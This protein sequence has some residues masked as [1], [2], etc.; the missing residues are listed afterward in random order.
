MRA[1]RYSSI[2]TDTYKNIRPNETL[3]L[4]A[5]TQSCL[6]S[7]KTRWPMSITQFA[8]RALTLR[9]TPAADP[10]LERVRQGE[11]AAVGE[12]YDLHHE[13]VRAFAVRLVGDESV[14]EDLVHEVF[15]Q[16][17]RCID[18]F[19]GDSSLRTFLT[20]VAVNHAR[21]YVRAASR[22][23]A[24][25]NRLSSEL[26]ASPPATP[27]SP[28]AEHERKEMVHALARAMDELSLAHRAVF[29][30]CDVEERSSKEA[31]KLLEVPE[32]TVRT[33]LFHARKKLRDSLS[34]EGLS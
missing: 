17:P 23:R 10:L 32:A 29:V 24:A 20:G 6:S 22:R 11:P 8:M 21:H 33:R 13:A 34:E 7:S 27:Q 5:G 26:T 9:R 15:V 18:K 3:C 4:R 1:W 19:R 30:L 12:L 2:I 25:T 16:L 28:E 31:A 14:A